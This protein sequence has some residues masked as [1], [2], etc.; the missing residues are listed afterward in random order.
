MGGFGT[1]SIHAIDMLSSSFSGGWVTP[2]EKVLCKQ[3]LQ[4]DIPSLK[5]VNGVGRY[6]HTYKIIEG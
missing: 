4:L 3:V 1:H 6:R 5:A 2:N